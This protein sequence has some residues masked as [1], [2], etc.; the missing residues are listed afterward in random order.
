MSNRLNEDAKGI[1]VIAATPFTD[2]V[3]VDFDSTDRL[4]E[5]DIG[6][7]VHGLTAPGAM[8]EA[9]RL[10]SAEQSEFMRHLLNRT[11]GRLPEIVG[12]RNPG[13]IMNSCSRDR[14]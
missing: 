8:G 6:E 12:V 9:P 1:Y 13:W 10:S 2:A 7:A 3:E 5:F 4:V 11:A 14:P